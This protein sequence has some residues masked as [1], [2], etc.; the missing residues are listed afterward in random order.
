MVYKRIEYL[1]NIAE[2]RYKK[3]SSTDEWPEKS[4]NASVFN[5]AFGNCYNCGGATFS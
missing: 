1:F 4:E 3:V 2:A 5:L